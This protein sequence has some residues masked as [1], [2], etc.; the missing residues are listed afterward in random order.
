MSEIDHF[1]PGRS[2]KLKVP[3]ERYL[4]SLPD[5][6]VE[7]YVAASTTPGE[8][9]LD[10]LAERGT[11]LLTAAARGR[12]GIA[13][14]FNPI[15]TLLVEGLLTLPPPDEIDAATTRLGDSPKRGVP[16]RE[17]IRSLYAS[18]CHACS[19][20]VTVDLFLWD[21]EADKPVE[22]YYHCP[23]CATDG[24]FPVQ[25]ADL[26]TLDRI[27]R[28]GVHYWYLL[29]RLAQPHQPERKLA[30]ELLELYTPRNLYALTD[31]SMKIE[32][33]FSSSPLHSALQLILLACLD[34]CSKLSASPLPRPTALRL[35]PPSKFVERN[36]WHAFEEA[37]RQV[38]SLS[39]PA[40]LA[41]SPRLDELVSEEKGQAIVINAPLRRLAS[42]LPPA[43]VSLV[44]TAPRSY[45]RPFWT[46]SYLWSGWLWGREKT[47]LFR[48]LL[49]RKVMGWSWYRE[50]L[51][52]ALRSLHRPLRA[53]GKMVFILE[54]ADLTHVSNLI[55]AAVGADFRLQTILYQAQDIHPPR[56]A[57]RGVEGAYR[58][59]FAR[60]ERPDHTLQPLSVE[61]LAQ[62]LQES[63]LTAA[64][65][66]LRERGE[67]IHFSWL[68]SA[69]YQRWS[70]D[71]LLRQTLM[72]EKEVSTTDFL[73]EQTEAALQEGLKTKTLDLLPDGSCED[74]IGC[75]WWLRGKGYPP[76]PLGDR[77]EEAVCQALKEA[78][79]V[80]HEP[81]RDSIYARFP[82]LFT[83]G[84]GLVEECLRSYGV[85]DE[86]SGHWQLGPEEEK[87]SLVRERDVALTAL[88]KLGQRFGYQVLVRGR[89]LQ[90]LL[91]AP[92]GRSQRRPPKGI[93]VAWEEEGEPCHL[94]AF[95]QT[96]ALA[97]ILGDTAPELGEGR[98]YTVISDRRLDFL[99]F[100][101]ENEVLLRRALAQGEWEFIKLSHLRTLARREKLDRQDLSQIVGLEP[102]IESPEAQLPLF[103]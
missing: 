72:L 71:D 25:E 60:D 49:R 100:R 42:M 52:A 85:Y 39:P 76:R 58:L 65:E 6:V 32:T 59:V 77:V 9:I 10:A 89:R 46:L 29:E 1:I 74:E 90:E 2:T 75:L 87:D 80:G 21:G 55:V 94:F 11:I 54:A 40:P 69:I 44:V 34:T 33:L 103:S 73:E 19:Q 97:D 78:A 61:I 41:L 101:M 81:L 63:A 66:M 95:R 7:A 86:A 30:Q 91:T 82:G 37:Y 24:Q 84:P 56:E 12:R 14:N 51:S 16:L 99:R 98:R 13:G 31:I 48:H 83:P 36:V 38:R 15:N 92:D 8:L 4:Q 35:H 64:R 70:R 20:P 53:Q 26:A 93:D 88:V 79:D 47:A 68:H 102:I 3:L 27:D 67:A 62:A 45:Y 57:M 5:N 50:S 28:Q 22:K 23:H 43:S 18:T 96:T 17:H